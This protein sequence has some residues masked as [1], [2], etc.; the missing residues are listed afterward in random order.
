MK[1]RE[2]LEA[3]ARAAEIDDGW[4]HHFSDWDGPTG[5]NWEWNPLTDDGDAL[6]L[7]LALPWMCIETSDVGVSVRERGNPDEPPR[8]YLMWTEWLDKHA[9]DVASATRRAIVRAAA[10]LAPA[11]PPQEPQQ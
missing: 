2:L 9:G 1:D 4:Q 10:A 3:A 11:T 7:F 8:V 6:R 5:D